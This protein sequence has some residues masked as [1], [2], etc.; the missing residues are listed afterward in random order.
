MRRAA[1]APPCPRSPFPACVAK[2]SAIAMVVAL[3]LQRTGARRG[4]QGVDS[5]LRCVHYFITIGCLCHRL[6][7]F[8]VREQCASYA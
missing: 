6:S 7:L 4:N 8:K 2:C 3:V 1:S 5:T